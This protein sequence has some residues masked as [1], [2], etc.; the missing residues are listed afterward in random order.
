MH[1]YVYIHT[2]MHA[3]IHNTYMYVF[4]AIDAL[5]GRIIFDMASSMYVQ[6]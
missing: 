1:I 6:R 3:Y 2:Y 5:D 4:T